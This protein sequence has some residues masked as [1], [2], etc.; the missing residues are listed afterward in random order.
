M[1]IR[2]K[3]YNYFKAQFNLKKSTKGF[4]RGNCPVCLGN[5]TFG[6]NVFRNRVNC[7]RCGIKTTPIAFIRDQQ[8]LDRNLEAYE[9]IQ[10]LDLSDYM[11]LEKEEIIVRTKSKTSITLPESFVSV[12]LAQGIIGKAVVA[13]LKR[14]GFKP[15]EL[16]L[17]GVGYCTKGEF[18]GYII[19][20]YFDK[21][22]L[23][24]YTARRFMG[25]GPKFKNIQEEEAGI[26][27][28]YILYN[29]DSLYI[30]KKIYIVESITN[31]WTLGDNAV[32]LA[33]KT[34]SSYQFNT[35]IKAPCKSI[36]IAL[37]PDA[38]DN[39]IG[40]ALKF[41][42]FKRVKILI[43]PE[44]KD[45]NDLGKQ[46]VKAIEKEAKYLSYSDIISLKN[47]RAELAYWK[48][49]PNKFTRTVFG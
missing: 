33:G 47:E 21:G 29:K 3:L 23:I 36:V 18:A 8:G 49:S 19:I 14:R 13:T 34:M 5:N 15:F 44:G 2:G 17:R 48:D 46:A 11:P 12:A 32:V 28:N 42:D 24:Y 45:V 31:A 4:I 22:R 26:G 20:P 37:D 1:S 41:V 6:V 10:K 27:K 43:L 16:A 35:I 40:M 25:I 39:A 38:L 30:Y 9:Y 7:F